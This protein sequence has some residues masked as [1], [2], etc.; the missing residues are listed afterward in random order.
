MCSSPGASN[1]LAQ[2]GSA[3]AGPEGVMMLG[4][5]ISEETGKVV[6]RRVIPSEG[7][8]PKLEVTVQFR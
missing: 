3:K 5:Q 2:L 4:E 8:D 6:L 1:K 7:G